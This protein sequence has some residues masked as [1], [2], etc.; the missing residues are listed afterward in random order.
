MTDNFDL[1]EQGNQ[2]N[3]AGIMQTGNDPLLTEFKTPTPE[4][5]G[6]EKPVEINSDDF[7]ILPQQPGSDTE[8]NAG[9]GQQSAKPTPAQ[10]MSSKVSA[11]FAVDAF[12]IGVTALGSVALWFKKRSRLGEDLE[13]A[14]VIYQQVQ[15]EVIKKAEVPEAD[16]KLYKRL[17]KLMQQQDELPLTDMER[18]EMCSSL[19][20]IFMENGYRMKPGMAFG[21][22]AFKTIAQRLATIFLD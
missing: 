21:I 5:N 8:N 11:E 14:E 9:P 6:G 17:A 12:D 3:S 10:L 15:D 7:D 16:R 19:E 2:H 18:D 22:S 4:K 13:A 1:P 20:K